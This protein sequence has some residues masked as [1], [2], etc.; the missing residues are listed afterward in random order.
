MK[1]TL[2]CFGLSLTFISAK[3]ISLNAQTDSSKEMIDHE[4]PDSLS[5]DSIGS[6][7][8]GLIDKI[9]NDVRRMAENRGSS[10]DDEFGYSE[11][12][13][14]YRADEGAVTFTGNT[15]IDASDTI[16]GNVVV[17]GG[18][19]TV[20]GLV[21]GDALAINGN[22]VVKDGG[23]ITG[24]ARSINGKIIK[25]G[26]GSIGGYSEETTS[27]RDAV[28]MS[29]GETQRRSYRFNDLWL[30]EPSLP[31]NF[32][33]RYNRVEGLFLGLGA[34]KKFYWDGSK[35]IS[36]YG[37]AGY[38]FAFHRWRAN[39]GLD[40]EFATDDALFEVGAE[41]HNITDTK[42]QWI[43][44]LTE[45][46]IAALLWHEDYRDY[47]TREGF[48]VHAARYT[49]ESN[50]SSQLRVDY[51]VDDYSSLSNGTNWSLFR[52][53]RSFRD[54]PAVTEGTMHSVLGTAGI[55]TLDRYGRRTIGWNA[56]ASLE[57]GGNALGGDFDFTRAI[58]DVRRFQPLS[59]YDKI[60]V[61]VR[62][63]SLQGDDIE[64]KSFEIGGANTLPAYAFKEFEGNRVILGNVE[65]VLS[66]RLMD[67]VSWWPRSLNL[68]LLADAGATD[69]VSTTKAL[70]EGFPSVTGSVIK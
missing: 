25:E 54:N 67:D 52:Q 10:R 22:I 13:R 27:I 8:D 2:L 61:R 12:G 34:E 35:S 4:G 53:S 5:N 23:K 70:W 51:L 47:F 65:Y 69:S 38:G 16:N 48:S 46:N 11:T 33:F 55:S 58:V 18:G 15:S 43:M 1:K 66:G 36:G 19:L 39:A 31:S 3:P 49:K 37:S 68:I 64:Q 30:G 17:K 32:V 62:V 42:D 14:S 21:D 26:T 59:E 20:I 24:N 6:F 60:N 9:E 28:Y 44:K 57:R 40:R 41:G 56:F 29:D 50:F 45:N 63:G 7:V